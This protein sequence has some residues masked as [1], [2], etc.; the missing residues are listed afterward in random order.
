MDPYNEDILEELD[1]EASGNMGA[2]DGNLRQDAEEDNHKAYDASLGVHC[3]GIYHVVHVDAMDDG[4]KDP[5]DVKLVDSE[6]GLEDD[7]VA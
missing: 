7:E 5:S 6:S 2:Q 4:A 1:A 3:K